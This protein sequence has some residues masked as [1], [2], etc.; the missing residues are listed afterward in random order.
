MC[1][2]LPSSGRLLRLNQGTDYPACKQKIIT[3]YI[4]LADNA[5]GKSY[6][7]DLGTDGRINELHRKEVVCE[8]TT[9]WVYIL[10]Q[11]G[12]S[13]GF[14]EHGNELSGF[15]FIRPEIS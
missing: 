15:D 3:A 10:L 7:E 14:C 5:V 13:G 1:L 9:L 6:L 11:I 8:V 2:Q 12:S 4:C